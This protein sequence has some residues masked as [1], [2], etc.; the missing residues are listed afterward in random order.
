[1]SEDAQGKPLA[2]LVAE[3]FADMSA[4]VTANRADNFGGAVLIYPPM[5]DPIEMLILDNTKSA[6][7]FWS[8]IQA[9]AKMALDDLDESERKKK[10]GWGR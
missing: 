7:M 4:R 1:M 3:A 6:G 2:D 9:L 10:Q 5:G 8:N